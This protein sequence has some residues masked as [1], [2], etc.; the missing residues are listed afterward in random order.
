MWHLCGEKP[1]EMQVSYR[2]SQFG[3]IN[4][5]RRNRWCLDVAVKLLHHVVMCFNSF[6]WVQ[7]DVNSLTMPSEPAGPVGPEVQIMRAANSPYVIQVLGV[8]PPQV[9]GVPPPQVLGVSPPVNRSSWAWWWSWWREDHWHP[10][11]WHW[12][13]L[14]VFWS[15]ESKTGH[16]YF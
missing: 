15:I 10:C 7:W 6:F 16:C 9:L 4:K 3:K 8:P 2:V 1:E 11:R 5:V 13:T 12:V 14:L